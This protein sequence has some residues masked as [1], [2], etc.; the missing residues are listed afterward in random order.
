MNQCRSYPWKSFG[1]AVENETD[2]KGKR[3]SSPR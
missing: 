1:S 2:L 3:L